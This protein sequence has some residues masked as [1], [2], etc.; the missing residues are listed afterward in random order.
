MRPTSLVQTLLRGARGRCPNCG[1]GRL[2]QGLFG[3]GAACPV[4]GQRFQSQP[5]D[6][7]GASVLSYALASVVGLAFGLLAVLF[8]EWPLWLTMTLGVALIVAVVALTY[9]PL[10]GLWIGFLVYSDF[11]PPPGAER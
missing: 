6:F 2:W 7:T 4:C 11:L 3:V 9:R 10:K 8:F 1:Q 5:G